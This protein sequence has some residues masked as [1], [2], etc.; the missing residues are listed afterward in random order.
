MLKE[1]II[2]EMC[3]KEIKNQGLDNL[4]TFWRAKIKKNLSQFSDYQSIIMLIYEIE[5]LIEK[6]SQKT[7]EHNDYKMRF[8]SKNSGPLFTKKNI[9]ERDPAPGNAPYSQKNL[10]VFQKVDKKDN[11]DNQDNILVNRL[12]SSNQIYTCKFLINFEEEEN[13]NNT[14]NIQRNTKKCATI[15]GSSSYFESDFEYIVAKKDNNYITKIKKS[16][17]YINYID[18]DLFFQYIALGKKFFENEEDNKDLIEGFCLQYQTFIFPEILI[19]RVIKCFNF[20][21]DKYLKKD[22][23]IIEEKVEDEEEEKDHNAKAPDNNCIEEEKKNDDNAKNNNDNGENKDTNNNNNETIKTIPYGLVDFMS[24]FINIH[25]TYFHNEL[26]RNAIER[27]Y[28]FLIQLKENKEIMEKYEQNIE[29]IE[30][31]LKEYES[32]LKTFRPRETITLDKRNENNSSSEEE[33]FNSEEDDDNNSLKKNLT[34]EISYSDSKINSNKSTTVNSSK[35]VNL[36]VNDKPTKSMTIAGTDEKKKKEKKKKSEKEQDDKNEL[37]RF[38]IIKYKTQDLA[39]ELTRISYALYSKIKIQ[40]FLKAVF[41]GKDKYKTSPHICQIIN[42]FNA[43]SSWVIEEILAYD[44][45]KKRAEIVIKFIRICM[46]LKKIGNF[47]DCLS[48]LT[49][50]N[51]YNINKLGKT[52]AR[53]PPNELIK[54][55][56]LNRFLSFEDNYKNMREEISKRIEEKSFFIPYLGYYTKRLIYLEELGPYIKK[57]T[58]LINIEKIVEVYKILHNFYQMK[59][60]KSCGHIIHDEN[61]KKELVILQCLDPSNEDSLTDISNAL[62]PKFVLSKDKLGTKRRTKTDI[63]FLCNI[64]KYNIL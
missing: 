59:N 41:N 18:I 31:E 17:Q 49:G 53:I 51:N 61:I 54:F 43:L 21:Y 1:K 50:L 44:H 40:E 56:G 25:N 22:N 19:D 14:V 55:K 13:K 29:L 3:E 20:F 63:N 11:I 2:M 24:T 39:L 36:F 7:E 48:L 52:W 12:N 46:A 64:N 28:D 10:D 4:M 8:I 47:D 57:N 45:S 23:E 33:G 30:I 35:F 42:R 38:D 62:E 58:S 37:Y 34:Q 27:I 9:F 26:S 5:N 60:V 32:S 6:I 15:G 16:K